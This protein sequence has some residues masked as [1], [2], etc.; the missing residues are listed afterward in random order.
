[1]YFRTN[2]VNKNINNQRLYTITAVSCCVIK[3][4]VILDGD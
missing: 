3:L 2:K 1:M 4:P